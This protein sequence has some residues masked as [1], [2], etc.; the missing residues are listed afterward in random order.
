MKAVTLF[1]TALAAVAYA[2]PVTLNDRAVSAAQVDDAATKLDALSA[3]VETL[4][5][6][7]ST[8]MPSPG[9]RL[10]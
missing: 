6:S 8:L 4:S 7:I 3:K 9:P 1:L 5:A 2:G 10:D